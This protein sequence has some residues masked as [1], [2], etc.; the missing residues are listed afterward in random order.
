[1]F[2]GFEKTDRAESEGVC[3]SAANEVRRKTESLQ[4]HQVCISKTWGTVEV[5]LGNRPVACLMDSKRR[6]EMKSR[7]SASLQRTE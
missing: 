6:T 5:V 1:M 4:A 3:V 2:G 7:E